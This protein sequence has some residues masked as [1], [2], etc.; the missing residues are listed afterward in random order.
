MILETLA[1]AYAED[2][3]YEKAEETIREAISKLN[4]TEKTQFGQEFEKIL[5]FYAQRKK[6]Y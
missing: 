2:G 5:N 1:A 3:Q 6:Y 4:T